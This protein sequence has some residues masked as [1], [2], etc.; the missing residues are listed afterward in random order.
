MK[1][2]TLGL[3]KS[4]RRWTG[5]LLM[6]SSIALLIST[7]AI[8]QETTAAMQGTVRDASGGSIVK[9]T[10]EVTSPALI[11]LKKAETDQVGYY[12]FANLPPGV[13]TLSVKATGFRAYKLENID[14][15]VG[16]LPTIDVSMEVG[17]TTETVE[18]SAE[19]AAI[20]TSQSKVQTNIGQT[21]LMNLPTQSLSYQSV[22]QFAPGA[23]YEP[24]Q[25]SGTGANNGF[26]INGASNSENSYLVDG[27]ETANIN[28][29]HS[30]ANVPMDFIDEVQVKTSGFEAEYGGA[31]G[32]VVNVISKRGS[33]EWHGSVFSYYQADRFNAAPN[34]TQLRNP[35][36]S[37]NYCGTR[38]DQP[39]EYYYPVKDHSRIADPGFTLGGDLIKDRLWIFLGSAP[40]FNQLRRTVN[41]AY[42]GA[43]G[44]RTFND[45]SYTYFTT[46]RVDVRAT[47]KIRLYGSWQYNYNRST[48]TSLPQADDVHGQFNSSSTSNP[49]NFN[50]GIGNVNPQVIYNVGADITLTPNLIATTR[51]GFFYYNTESRGLPVGIQYTYRDTNYSY[52]TGDAPALATTK[53]LDGTALPSQFVNSTG[54]SNIGGNSQTAFD[55]WKR[56]SFSQDLSY[57]KTF[58]GTHN[59][60]FGY[61]FNHGFANEQLG[62]YNTA[63]VYVGY[64]IQYVPQTTNGEARCAAIVAQ[65]Q[66][67]YGA[68]GGNANGTACQGLWGTVNIRDLIS[69]SG[70]VGNWNHA[71]YVQDAWTVAK[72]L[73][74]N[75]GL[76]L[77][78]ENLPSYDSLPGFE[79]ISFGWGQKIAPRLGAA[80]DLLH[81]GKVKVYGSFG[82]FYDIMK[83]NLPQG[84]FGGAYWHDC[85]YALDN[86][87]YN[88]IIPQRDAQGH[89]C[90]VGGGA[91][92]ANG[93]FPAGGLRF[94]ENYD[95]R[96][97][98]NDPNQIGSL[99][100]TGLVDPNLKP[101]K[102]HVITIGAAWE[103]SH[104]LVFEPVYTRTRL[105][106]TIE[107]AGTITQNGEVYYITNPG[108][109]VNATVPNCNGCPPNPKAVR[110]YDGIE[111]RLT[112]RMNKQWMGVFSYTYSRLY[113]NYDGL[114]STDISDSV[115]RNGA[116]T[117]RAFDEPFMQ[118]NAHGQ[119]INGPL[120]TDRPN[121]FKA[122]L[123]YNLKYKQLNTVIGLFQQVYSGTPLSSY[124]SVWGAPVFVEGR[125]KFVNM[126][127]DPSTGNWVEGSVSDARTPHFS[128]T[129]LSAYQDFHVS[130]SNERLI[131]RVGADCFNC[132]NQH[133]VT[134]INSNLIRTGSINPAPCG[135]AGTNCTP[136]E[137]D[138][139]GFD[140]GVLNS[141][142][143]D[144]VGL[145]NAAG[146]SLSSL[147]GKPQAWQNP[148]TVRFQVRFTF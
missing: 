81:N 123:Y 57:F 133:H 49:D 100:P 72:G 64:N 19:A 113:G 87:N 68:P 15:Q 71:F 148:R 88:L 53:A 102:Q 67:L 99:G 140:Y 143:Y 41:F 106:R 43:S 10:V 30:M 14:L 5:Q 45:N 86:P 92:P 136:T 125:G 44:A 142:G 39:L 61:G 146:S 16:H 124:E 89:Y 50:G 139:A 141:K 46:A 95:Y 117:D 80:Y 135:S 70:K 108:F 147:Y 23:R 33:N 78:K 137:A 31:L 118:F 132:F 122:N 103:L 101:M 6:A 126:T 91:T 56:Y 112:K 22:I 13:Y 74:L 12:R 120:A 121:T 63:D 36:F 29:G 119:A 115:G 75:L 105:D 20:D 3:D 93:I 24:L 116:N 54:Y 131:A 96:E 18:V 109:G 38:C 42:P 144:Y 11:G 129:D 84:S 111:F 82:Y 65:N 127:R 66:Q 134:I 32:G 114:T 130:K 107:D 85:V 47:Q 58:L 83:F 79:G 7:C 21:S 17:A 110:D 28:D 48:G 60:K 37:N 69:A 128:Q 26:Q 8:A 40:D 104:N 55:I 25:N 52:N 27:Q 62:V 59:L 4:V 138:Q 1:T 9:A 73:T 97:P 35:Q 76:R 94:I 77:D 34:P 90:P 98:A 51:Y 145:S 2:K